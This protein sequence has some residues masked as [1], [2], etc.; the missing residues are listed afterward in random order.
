[1]GKKPAATTVRKVMAMPLSMWRD[2]VRFQ[3]AENILTE[4]ETVRR[5]LQAALRA[6][7]AKAQTK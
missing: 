2:V 1:M 7:S 4:T 5:L 6:E 3:E